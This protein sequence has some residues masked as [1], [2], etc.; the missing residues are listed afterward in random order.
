[1]NNDPYKVLGVSPDA[2]DEQVKAAY[3]E[4]A[5]KYHPDNYTDNPLSD[6]A[7]EKMKEINEAYDTVIRSRRA[8]GGSSAAGG[9]S[10]VNPGGAGSR[11]A[12]VRAMINSGRVADA[13]TVLDGVPA[14]S[15]DAEWNFLKGCVAYRKGWLEEA[16]RYFV[17]ASRMDPGNMEYRSA[18]SRMEAQRSTGGYRTATPFGG[19]GQSCDSCDLCTSLMCANCLCNCLR[20]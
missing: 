15:R 14:A 2:S 18:V 3:R 17:T 20:C 5:R 16:Y 10:T 7:E 6:L 13:E 4:L 1:M 12:D 11:Y 19:D 8:G 9:Y